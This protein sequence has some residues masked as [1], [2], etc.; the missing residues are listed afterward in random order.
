MRCR[1]MTI[2]LESFDTRQL[3]VKFG[4]ALLNECHS[5]SLIYAVVWQVIFRPELYLQLLD[6]EVVQL[7]RIFVYDFAAGVFRKMSELR[8]EKFL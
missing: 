8:V 1:A 7:R 3:E 5:F 6:R 2:L 4:S